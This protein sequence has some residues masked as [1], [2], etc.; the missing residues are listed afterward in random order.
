MVTIFREFRKLIQIRSFWLYIYLLKSLFS[1]FLVIPIYLTTNSVLSTSSYSRRLLTDWDLSVIIELLS[2]RE[3]I[4]PIY[5]AAIFAGAIVYLIIMQFINGGIYY[6]M[7]SGKLSPING[8]DFFAECGDGFGINLKISLF[9]LLIYT[10]LLPSA[11]FFVNVVSAT[12]GGT[13]G[14]PVLLTSLFKAGIVFLILAAASIFSD[15]ARAAA[16]SFP[17]KSFGEIVK[18]AANYYRPNLLKLLKNFLVT[19][20]LFVVIWLAVEIA[21]L[22]LIGLSLGIIGVLAEFILFQISSAA[23]TGQKIWYLLLLG[24]DF[25]S[26]YPGRFL[27]EQVEMKLS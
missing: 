8:R 3:G 25:Q 15:S 18:M 1:L 10:V 5:F 6:L 20:I 11:L 2:G 7:V 21:A 9:M 27:P 23:R 24:K 16:V 4:L 13:T 12:G 26:R 14:T 19:Y 17:G 22:A